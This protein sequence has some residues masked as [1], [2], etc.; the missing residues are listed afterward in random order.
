M[1][2]LFDHKWPVLQVV[3][4]LLDLRQLGRVDQLALGDH[5]VGQARD[6]R[7]YVQ[8]LQPEVSHSELCHDHYMLSDKFWGTRLGLP[9]LDFKDFNLKRQWKLSA[10]V[11]FL[12]EIKIYLTKQTSAFDNINL[13]RNGNLLK[14]LKGRFMNKRNDFLYFEWSISMRLEMYVLAFDGFNLNR[15]CLFITFL[16]FRF[17]HNVRLQ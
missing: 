4:E 13:N 8:W 17:G 2:N 10:I 1:L 11:K 3:E 6:V 7:T 12:I 5:L 14:S 15:N 9:L 16:K